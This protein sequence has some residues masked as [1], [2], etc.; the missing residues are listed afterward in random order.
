MQP[1]G[2]ADL[3]SLLHRPA[4]AGPAV[5]TTTRA[6]NMRATRRRKR[7]TQLRRRRSK[8]PT[9]L[10]RRGARDRRRR[11]TQ[12]R[13]GRAAGRR[14]NGNMFTESP[15]SGL[16]QLDKSRSGV[17]RDATS[18]RRNARNC[19]SHSQSVMTHKTAAAAAR[20]ASGRSPKTAAVAVRSPD[21]SARSTMQHE[22]SRSPKTAAAAA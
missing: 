14:H 12:L 4:P 9:R 3:V 10:Q 16:K 13:V 2:A 11:P 5:C 20:D 15:R 17:C 7:P 19:Y 8:R 6:A 22:D 18:I 21:M 1:M